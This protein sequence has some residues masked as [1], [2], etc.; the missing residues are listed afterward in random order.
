VLDGMQSLPNA[1]RAALCLEPQIKA[2]AEKYKGAPSM[3][4]IGRNTGYPIALEGAQKLKEI[5]YIHAEAYA[6]SELKHG[7]IALVSE[8]FPTVVVLPD[9]EL[10]EKNVS[11]I[12][13]VRARKGPVIAVTQR[14]LDAGLADDV[15]IVPKVTKELDPIVLNIPLQLLAYHSACA[16]G[17]DVD[18]PRNLAKSVTVE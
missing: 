11:S 5:S 10:F 13:Q 1:I 14:P 7:P 15:L 9:D 8:T 18:Q 16:L 3:F 12:Q 17:R 4:F 6:A 2:I